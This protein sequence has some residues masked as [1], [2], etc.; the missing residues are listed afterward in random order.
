MTVQGVALQG[1]ASLWLALPVGFL[2]TGFPFFVL[3]IYTVLPRMKKISRFARND[4][5]GRGFTRLCVIM[6]GFARR[7]LDDGFP[8]FRSSL[9]HRFA[10]NEKDFSLRSK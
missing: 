2:M 9:M 7:F 5:A 1:F 3:R 10:A 8:V 4:G 6:A